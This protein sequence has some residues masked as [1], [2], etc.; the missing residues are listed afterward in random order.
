MTAVSSLP[1]VIA[2]RGASRD[3]PENTPAAF[4]AAIALGV[5]A[6]ELDV[7][8]T[9][10]GVL[11][12]HHN[13]SRRGVPLALLTYSTLVRL[14]RHVPPRLD[15]VLD[16]CAGRISLD[17]EVKE[18]GYEAE[19]IEAASSRF[20]RDQLLYTSFEEPVISTI[21]HLDPSARCGLLLGPGRLRS[22]TQ[23][24]EGLPFDLAER[25]G[26]D[27]LA[28]HQWLAPLRGRSRRIPGTGLLA[29]AQARGF[30][31]MVWTVDGPH[32]LRAYLADGRVAGIITDLPGLA[33]E[34][35]RELQSG[36]V[37]KWSGPD[38]IPARGEQGDF[39]PADVTGPTWATLT[40]RVR[41]VIPR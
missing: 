6:V 39:M 20:P 28:V 18:P 3:A 8:R 14:S 22:R 4:E 29:E 40:D 32:R 17:I 11:V 16:L 12:V 1:L 27:L 13:A 41:P 23:R 35:R 21:K 9:A 36:P 34:T 30:P 15:T 5:D 33:V 7:R 25:C 38:S 31:M 37:G 2:H 26:A 10:D 24:Y 19:V